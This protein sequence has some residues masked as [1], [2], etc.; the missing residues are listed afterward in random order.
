[1]YRHNLVKKFEDYC[2]KKLKISNN[3][4][5][6]H[7]NIK[8]IHNNLEIYANEIYTKYMERFYNIFRHHHEYRNKRTIL[9][10][11]HDRKKTKKTA[12]VP[13]SDALMSQEQNTHQ[14]VMGDVQSQSIQPIKAIDVIPEIK[15]EECTDEDEH[16]DDVIDL[17]NDDS[18]LASS[19]LCPQN[20]DIDTEE[21]A[22]YD[23]INFN[24]VPT[25]SQI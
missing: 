13:N 14:S 10:I 9:K 11:L 4:E 5:L 23:N 25:S 15:K 22:T 16:S 17:M 24:L 20:F 12:R 19:N 2:F 8:Y 6:Q 18:I 1:M 21:I 7:L 3:K